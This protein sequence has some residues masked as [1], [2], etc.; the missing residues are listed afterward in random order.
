MQGRTDGAPILTVDAYFDGTY[1]RLHTRGDSQHELCARA[2]VEVVLI[3][4]K[5]ESSVQSV[6][7]LGMYRI[8]NTQYK[9]YKDFTGL[10]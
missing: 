5:F 6:L 4:L 9:A 2:C 8:Q 10:T 7:L 1:L 3:G